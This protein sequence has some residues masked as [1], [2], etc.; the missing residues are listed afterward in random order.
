MCWQDVFDRGFSAMEKSHQAALKELRLTHN[1]ELER[2]QREKDDLLQ[3][4]AQDTQA[5]RFR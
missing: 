3:A 5:G 4:E 2:L 1:K